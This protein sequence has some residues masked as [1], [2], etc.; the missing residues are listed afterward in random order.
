MATIA[1]KASAGDVTCRNKGRLCKW[2]I[3]FYRG[4]V[5]GTERC[6][7]RMGSDSMFVG[8]EPILGL[9]EAAYNLKQF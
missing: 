8:L 6:P 7:R 5:N 1:K 9:S 3:S 4:P 2:G